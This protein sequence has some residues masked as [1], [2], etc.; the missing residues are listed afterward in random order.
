MLTTTKHPARFRLGSNADGSAI[1]EHRDLSVCPECATHPLCVEV[2][3]AHF[4]VADLAERD[5]LLAAIA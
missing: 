3:G 4:L 2:V 5:E 1:C